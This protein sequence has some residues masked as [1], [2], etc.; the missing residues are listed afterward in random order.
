MD[1]TAGSGT[2][3]LYST[4]VMKGMA[5]K[6]FSELRARGRAEQHDRRTTVLW[7]QDQSAAVREIHRHHGT[8]ARTNSFDLK[9]YN[10]GSTD[11]DYSLSE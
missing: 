4:L 10:E 2:S 6:I 5:T 1:R 11:V 8:Y 3:K 9:G 7:R